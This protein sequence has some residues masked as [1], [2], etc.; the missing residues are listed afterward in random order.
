MLGLSLLGLTWTEK[1]FVIPG[2]I[3]VAVGA[4]YLISF[5]ISNRLAKSRNLSNEPGPG[6]FPASQN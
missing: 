3:L 6:N 2:V 5:A 4:G 1:D